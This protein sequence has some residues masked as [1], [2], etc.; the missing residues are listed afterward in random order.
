MYR[1]E[2]QV[3]MALCLAV[4]QDDEAWRWHERL[5][6]TKFSSLEKM[7]KLEMVRGLPLINHTK[8]FCNTCVLAKHHHCVFLK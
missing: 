5:G 3:A 2:L 7:S 1:L 8:Q 6:H 4:H